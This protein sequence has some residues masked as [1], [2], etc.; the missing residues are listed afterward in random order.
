[1]VDAS[2]RG[3]LT[4]DE[5]RQKIESGEIETI[6]AV[7]TDL[8]GRFMGKRVTGEFF[9]QQTAEH[10]LHACDYLLTVDLPMEPIPGYKFASWEL[11]YGDFH[12]EPDLKTLRIASWL[13]KSALVIC[14]LSN[15]KTHEPISVAPRSILNKQ[16]EEAA[17]AGYLAQGASELEYFIFDETYK[18]ARSK[19]YNNLNYFGDYVEDYHILQGTREEVLNAAVRRHLMNSG[20]PVEFTKGEW[21]P[22]QHELNIRYADALTIADHHS[23]YKQCF[24][25]VADQLN[26]SV[27]F[28]AKPDDRYAGSGSHI[29]LSLWDTEGKTNIFDGEQPLGPIQC[30]DTFRWFLG[31][32]IA[33]TRE[34]MPFYAPTI[35]SYKRYQ[36][37][38]WAPTS[39]AWSFD[40]RTAGFRAVGHGKSLRIESRIPGADVNPYLAYAAA[41]ASGLDGIRNKIEPPP[42]FQGDVYAAKDLPQVPR[43]LQEAIYAMERSAF[44]REAFGEDV[45]EHYLHFYKTEQAAYDKA[46]T[47]WERA[48]YFEQI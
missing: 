31:G 48:R 22:G 19:S 5:L 46:V 2:A 47:T 20:I 28:M 1:M 14:D 3:M 43:T 33:H 6:V 9:L 8:Y 10:G 15:D 13:D 34:L 42:I 17:K 37:G 45:I 41:L 29:H 27:S 11:G 40:N 23:I 18:S 26:L 24:K 39:L 32:W 21:G 44:A 25:E 30:S 36:S 7:F 16:V 38:S 4:L 35:N 12:C